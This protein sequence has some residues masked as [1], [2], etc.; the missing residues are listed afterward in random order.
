MWGAAGTGM[1]V[2]Q[3]A[4]T[5]LR[6]RELV[7]EHLRELEQLDRELRGS[8]GSDTGGATSQ[9]ENLPP[10]AA[11]QSIPEMIADT[12]VTARASLNPGNWDTSAFTS[13]SILLRLIGQ[14]IWS[15]IEN[16]NPD[17]FLRI[18]T[19]PLSTLNLDQRVY[20]ELANA[21]AQMINRRGG[22]TTMITPELLKRLSPL[23][24]VEFMEGYHLLS[25]T[26]GSNQTS[27]TR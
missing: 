26:S 22:P 15:R 4:A 9:T 27:Q 21:M 2:A 18:A 23:G 16:A 12:L 25:V 6:S 11:G 1:D 14:S 5:Y 10:V 7:D 13:G 20:I 17:T 3:A 24:F 19:Q 8:A